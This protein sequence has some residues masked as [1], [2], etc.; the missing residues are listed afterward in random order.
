MQR[1]VQFGVRQAHVADG[2]SLAD[3]GQYPP[4][5]IVV[6]SR[7]R[8]GVTLFVYEPG[9][10]Q[11]Q[12]LHRTV[13][14][15]EHRVHQIQNAESSSVE[16]HDIRQILRNE[17]L[18]V[19]IHICHQLHFVPVLVFLQQRYRIT[20][21]GTRIILVTFLDGIH[22]IFDI[23]AFIR[24][25]RG[26]ILVVPP[27]IPVVRS[28]VALQIFQRNRVGLSGLQLPQFLYVGYGDISIFAS[29]QQGKRTVIPRCQ[30]EG[31]R[32]LISFVVHLRGDL[33]TLLL[34]KPE[35]QSVIFVQFHRA[36]VLQ[37]AFHPANR[38]EPQSVFIF[39]VHPNKR[40]TC[41][42]MMKRQMHGMSVLDFFGHG[43]QRVGIEH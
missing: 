15:V 24:P 14:S 35:I 23:K 39:I 13:Q 21:Q 29:L 2:A 11:I 17:R 31:N 12:V 4:S 5:R 20:I 33:P 42:K 19:K 8:I 34:H 16:G 30:M 32:L 1:N 18:S 38:L 28:D 6:G 7:R 37:R 25:H 36:G 26:V 22:E 3:T 27:I 9:T 40:Q 43:F 10:S 41:T